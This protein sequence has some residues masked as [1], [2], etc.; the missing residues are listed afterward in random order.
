MP[1]SMK[2]GFS[3]ISAKGLYFSYTGAAPYILNGIDF[4]ILAGEYISVVGDNGSG[5]TT[6]M[7]LILKMIRACSGSIESRAKMTGYVPQRNNGAESGFPITV[8]EML[9]SYRKLLKVKDKNV[10]SENLKLV[11]MDGF[12]SALTKNLSGGQSQK[13]L[14]ARALMGAPDLLVLDE[15]STGID[16]ASRQ[17]IYRILRDI[18]R[19]KG[20]TII[21]VEHNL[22]AA[23]S[24]STRIYHL[25]GGHGHICTPAQYT[26]EYMKKP[27][28]F[29][30]A[31]I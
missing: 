29:G 9:N 8:H 21:S 22:Q 20:I 11:G 2:S 15:P 17:D 27:E 1:I 30:N 4:D 25:A 13:T 14:I 7:R 28:G 19:N 3:M 10:V 26:A 31:E 16:A 23:V 6:L 5:K 24:N 12:E 18:N